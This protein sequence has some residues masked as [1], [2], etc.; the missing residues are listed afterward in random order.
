MAAFNFPSSPSNGDSHSQNGVTFT[1]SSS[2]GA[3][4]RSSAV[5]AQG[6]TGSTGA[7]GATGP[8]GST[9]AQGATGPTGAQGATA[10]Q[11]AQG[12]AGA[13]GATGGGG[14][15]GAQGA[16]GSNGGTDIVNDTSPQLGGDLDTN[17]HHI[18]IDDDHE[19]KFGAS[20]DLRMFHAGGNANFMQSYND[21]YLRIQTF[22]TSAQIRLQTNES[23]NGVICS[24]NGATELGHS[25]NIKL[26][27][28]SSGVQ[29]TGALNVTTTMHI[30]DD[31]NGLQI[32]NSNDLRIRHDGNNSIMS[33]S[34]TGDLLI[35]TAAGEKIYIDSS[36]V[37]IRN[38][39]S[40]E[41]MIQATENGG[42][43][44]RYNNENKFSTET[45]GVTTRNDSGTTVFH[46]F[47]TNGGTA[48][49]YVYANSSDQVGFLNE[50]Q[51]WVAK[52]D[53][54]SNCVLT[55]HW[56]PNSNNSYDLGS[57]SLRWR[58][59]YSFDLQLSNKGGA[60]DVDGTWGDYTIQEG[61]SKLFVINNRTGKK[62]SL[63]MEEE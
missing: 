8:T 50:S 9:G 43:N 26:A 57:S 13:Q 34:G 6:A 39:A 40:N 18:L 54:G 60:N 49:G 16:A 61:E 23:Q 32:G 30:P 3:W 42:V 31:S 59:V 4:Q 35:N 41:T 58:N 24:A 47:T 10:A 20:S 56:V 21:N 28:T 44:L 55:G 7:Q 52:F 46:R 27:T 48:R 53:T 29:V 36:E 1:Y 38:A 12:A 22:G 51:N 14:S 62:Y 63:V 25:G 33:H 2:S 11:G 19:V 45:N 37:I 15:T 5:G 17:S